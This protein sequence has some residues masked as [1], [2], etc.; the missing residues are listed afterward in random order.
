MSNLCR[1]YY[2]NSNIG[3]DNNNGLSEESPFQTL[4]AVNK[5]K[6]MAG[7]RVLLSRKSVFEN[8]FLNIKD[9]GT[10]SNP[11]EIGAYGEG[12]CPLIETNGQGI[13][14][15]N[16][17]NKL[18]SESHV[19]RGYVSSAILLYDAEYIFIHDI[20]ITN[21]GCDIEGES[22]S[23]SDKM[24][25]TGVSGIAQNKGTIRGIHL[26]NLFIHDINGNVYDKH[27]NNGGI[28]FTCLLPNNEE[29][30]GVARY[31]DILIE[32][33]FVNNVSRWGIAIGY[34]YAHKYF[35]KA[36]LEE[37]LFHKYGNENIVIR[38]N[39]VR[40][41]GGG[42][43]T[44]MYAIKPVAEHNMCESI[45]YEMNDRIYK[46]PENRK[47]KLAAGIWPWK[48]KDALFKYNSVSDMKLN[49][50]GM[51][52]DFD[53]ADGTVYDTNYSRQNEGGCVMLCLE[54]AVNS[55][56]RNNI[57]F[58]DLGGTISPAKNPDGLLENNTFYKRKETPFVRKN[59]DGG[60][61]TEKNNRIV[62]I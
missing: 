48:C 4:F 9:G 32:D 16:Y 23:L 6:L 36:Y 62:E 50:D 54:E 10:E 13:W 51:A 29:K 1:T 28:Y 31:K 56:F 55:T 30:T 53:S 45:A 20:E 34:T 17:G 14:Y 59:M 60:I 11:I 26:K 15:Q 5:L 35:N 8:Q 49:Q 22:Y 24:N 2:V 58:D 43:I 33:C 3:N 38:N 42:G 47:G 52:Y 40:H 41:A 37:E 12:E 44:V 19:Y 57:S 21:R 61:Y 7:D 46:F 39:Y 25:R 18:D 27:M